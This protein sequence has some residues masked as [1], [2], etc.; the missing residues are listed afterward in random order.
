MPEIVVTEH[1]ARSGEHVSFYLASG[2][3]D[4]PLVILAHGWPELALSWR[5]QLP[6]LAGLG[7]RAVAPDMRGYGRSSVYDRHEDYAME[8]VAGDML[9]LIDHLGRERAVWVGHDWGSPVVWSVASHHPERC[10]A[11]ASLCVPY[12]TIELGLDGLIALVDRAIYPEDEYPAGQWEYMRHYAEQF[13]KATASMDADPLGMARLLFRK[14]NPDGRGKPAGTAYVRKFDG[15]FRGAATPP[16]V[17]RDGDVVSEQELS[18][19]AAALARNGFFGPN[20]YYMNHEANRA[21]AARSVNGGRL[22][23]P[24][25]FL[26][27][28]YDYTCET[29]N[30]RLGEP[31]REHCADLSWVEVPSGHWMAQERPAEVNA[32]L[33]RWLAT[34]VPQAWPA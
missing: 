19:Y 2:P 18:A 30:S 24:A 16:A 3:E 15:W 29:I 26:A 33:V 27:A 13:A 10:H 31:M 28:S 8:R 6:V 21:Y 34:K 1:V 7:F 25:L 22:D 23:M 20:S 17:P 4:G 5:H 12:G 32:A 11:V 9:A 14:G